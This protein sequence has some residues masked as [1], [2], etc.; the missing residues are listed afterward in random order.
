[1]SASIARFTRPAPALVPLAPKS[2]RTRRVKVVSPC[3]ALEAARYDLFD[4]EYDYL[5]SSCPGI[6][7]V[8]DNGNLF[9]QIVSVGFV[10]YLVVQH[11]L[12]T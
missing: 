8:V 7:Y 6:F 2:A 10:Y 5:I 12:A 11:H 3:A 9:Q 1:M 4:I